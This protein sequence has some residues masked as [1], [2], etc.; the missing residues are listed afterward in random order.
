MERD[1]KQELEA[2]RVAYKQSS[3]V[4]RLRDIRQRLATVQAPSGAM[5]LVMA[6]SA[7]E[8]LARSLVVHAA[9]RPSSTADMRYRQAQGMAA[10]EL[11]EEVLRLH[12]APDAGMRFGATT[13]SLFELAHQYRD[14]AVHECTYA[15]RDGYA[16]LVEAAE[17]VLQGL[18]EA[19]ELPRRVA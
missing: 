1:L 19:S 10:V 11:V 3:P 12:G 15:D 2:L 9:G 5:R 18:V 13:W 4:A 16:P 7:V 14:L 8:A 6:L 17:T